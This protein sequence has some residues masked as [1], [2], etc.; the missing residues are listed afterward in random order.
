MDEGRNDEALPLQL[1]LVDKVKAT[2]KQ[3]LA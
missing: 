3:R 1:D 2:A